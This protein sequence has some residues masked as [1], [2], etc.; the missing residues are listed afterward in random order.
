MEKGYF[1]KLIFKQTIEVQSENR[2][3][4]ATAHTGWSFAL[5]T[6]THC[7]SLINSVVIS[8]FKQKQK[9]RSLWGLSAMLTSPTSFHSTE[10]GKI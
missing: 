8:C 5:P 6:H 2:V 4:N 7:L 9:K 10:I 3:L 1:H